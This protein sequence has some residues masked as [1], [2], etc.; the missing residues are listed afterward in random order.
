M[1]T[2]LFWV[3]PTSKLVYQ[4]IEATKA[5]NGQLGPTRED[6]GATPTA[7]SEDISTIRDARDKAHLKRNGAARIAECASWITVHARDIQW[8]PKKLDRMTQLMEPVETYRKDSIRSVNKRNA[9]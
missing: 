7:I 8:N 6:Y 2:P 9:S 4:E 3:F 5:A 1:Y